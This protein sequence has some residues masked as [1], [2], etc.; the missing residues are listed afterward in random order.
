MEIG[1]FS[2]PLCPVKLKKALSVHFIECLNS[3]IRSLA[4]PWV[5]PVERLRRMSY[6][7]EGSASEAIAA[8][9]YD[10]TRI[11]NKFP[12]VGYAARQTMCPLCPSGYR[13][14]VSHLAF[15]CPSMEKF[16]KART[17]LGSFRNMCKAKAF[18]DEKV[19]ELFVNGM[20]WNENPIE[21]SDFLE[22]GA[23]LKLLLDEFLSRW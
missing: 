19:Y 10:V 22:R 14:T 21:L 13:N 17:S 4:L 8:F 7:R 15:F 12:R 11:G 1:L 18:T 9:R 3:D 5:R 16:R 2:L 23:D 20:D 6:A